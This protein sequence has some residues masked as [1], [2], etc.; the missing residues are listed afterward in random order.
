MAISAAVCFVISIIG[1]VG[2]GLYAGRRRPVIGGAIALAGL[3]LV[4]VRG[5][6]A[7]VPGLEPTLYAWADYPYFKLMPAGFGAAVLLSYLARKAPRPS[8]RRLIAVLLALMVAQEGYYSLR[9]VLAERWYDGLTG[10]VDATGL[11]V[12]TS[13]HTCGAAAAAMLLHSVGIPVTER[14]M[15]REC[16]VRAGVGVTDMT[17]LRGLR[18]KLRGTP[19]RVRVYRNLTY[20]ELARLP[21][22]CLVSLRQSWFLDHAVIVEW[23]TRR[24][25]SVLDPDEHVGRVT[26][27]RTLFADAWRGDALVLEGPP[28]RRRSGG[29]PRTLEF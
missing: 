21:K 17:L 1:G 16:L 15:A 5:V 12:Q 13:P 22:P 26:M 3:A 10:R 9:F 20:N 18:R 25:V 29:R 19:W 14:E 8:L 28:G 23:A 24:L 27:P 7:Y 2:L 6:I 11:C 4:V